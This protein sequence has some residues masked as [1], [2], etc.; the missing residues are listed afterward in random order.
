[1]K[2]IFFLSIFFLGFEYGMRE[3]AGNILAARKCSLDSMEL[4]FALIVS[5]I[6]VN[7]AY[8]MFRV[9]RYGLVGIFG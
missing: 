3:S 9:L 7:E 1:M 4:C 6:S 8:S 5:V 2:C